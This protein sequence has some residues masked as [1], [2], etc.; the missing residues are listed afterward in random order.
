[1]FLNPQ[2]THKHGA[3]SWRLN[4]KQTFGAN[5]SLSPVL[6]QTWI[7][8]VNDHKKVQKVEEKEMDEEQG[9]K[10]LKV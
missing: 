1:M 10:E 2:P 5:H 4:A 8:F 6:K 9:E 7:C 3:S